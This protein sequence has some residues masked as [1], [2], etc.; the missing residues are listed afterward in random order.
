MEERQTALE[1]GWCVDMM[2]ICFSR[3]WRKHVESIKVKIENRIEHETRA[4][5]YIKQEIEGDRKKQRKR[6]RGVEV[7]EFL[8]EEPRAG[9]QHKQI[10]CDDRL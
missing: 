5:E 9:S 7:S 6:E 1:D 4:S 8:D 10:K 3:Q 2:F